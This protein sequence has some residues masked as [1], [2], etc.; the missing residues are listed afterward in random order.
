MKSEKLADVFSLFFR[1][2]FQK[3]YAINNFANKVFE[4]FYEGN[5]FA[6]KVFEIFYRV[7]N[8]VNKVFEI[9]YKGNNFVNKVFEIIY[10]GNN[11][12]HKVKGGILLRAT[13]W[14]RREFTKL[15]K[16]IHVVI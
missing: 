4:I 10:K 11:F 5:N 8:F 9:I 3:K 6:N 7:N 1:L 15:F 16:N 2:D 13:T 14:Q 12:K